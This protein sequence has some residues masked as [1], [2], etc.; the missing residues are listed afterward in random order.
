MINKYIKFEVTGTPIID[1]VILTFGILSIMG[2]LYMLF[3]LA[4]QF[5]YSV[6]N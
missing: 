5:Y 2:V 3:N 4:T 6:V 1:Y